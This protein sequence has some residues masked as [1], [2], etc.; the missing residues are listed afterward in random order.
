M[1]AGAEIIIHDTLVIILDFI[2]L[3]PVAGKGHTDAEVDADFTSPV[4]SIT[5]CW[6]E[7]N[8]C[9]FRHISSDAYIAERGE[10]PELQINTALYEHRHHPVIEFAVID[11]LRSQTHSDEKHPVDLIAVRS[12]KSCIERGVVFSQKLP[13]SKI[14]VCNLVV[15][16]AAAPFHE[17]AIAALRLTCFGCRR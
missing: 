7:I 15:T 16:H 13:V 4:E 12:H 9:P 14:S 6:R 5:D 2:I 3:L 11:S 10:F 1:T 17:S 8:S